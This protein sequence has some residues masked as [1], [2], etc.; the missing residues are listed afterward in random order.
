MEAIGFVT[1]SNGS[2][3]VRRRDADGRH[4][5]STPA[6]CSAR[7]SGQNR[8]ATVAQPSLMREFRVA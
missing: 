4:T 6:V 8:N 2:F 5:A 1:P 3:D 7:E